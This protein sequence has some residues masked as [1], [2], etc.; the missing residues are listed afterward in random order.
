MLLAQIRVAASKGH[1]Q[2][3]CTH[4][5]LSPSSLPSPRRVTLPLWKSRWLP[6]PH[7]LPHRRGFR[8]VCRPW[9]TP[10]ACTLQAHSA[11]PHTTTCAW[12]RQVS[13][14]CP[15]PNA[16]GSRLPLS[17]GG[18]LANLKLPSRFPSSSKMFLVPWSYR[19]GCPYDE[20]FHLSHIMLLLIQGS[21]EAWFVISSHLCPCT[22][23]GTETRLSAC[24]VNEVFACMHTKLLQ[25]CLTLCDPM[26]SSP[27]GSS[28]HRIL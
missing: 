23:P 2:A 10:L 9:P 3:V 14:S 7:T 4:P 19:R 24:G 25:L 21:L 8:A 13:L 6:S 22:E 11:Q 18:I 12:P 17:T 5:A 16:E 28:V 15:L 27:P 26:D 20:T 1:P